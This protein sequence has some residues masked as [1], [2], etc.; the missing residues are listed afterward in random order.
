MY[1]VVN[2]T[3]DRK[4]GYS[5]GVAGISAAEF[6][7]SMRK[8]GRKPIFSGVAFFVSVPQ[9]VGRMLRG[10]MPA[11]VTL[12]SRSFNLAFG[13]P[14]LF[15]R[16]I[17]GYF[18]EKRG[19]AMGAQK[20]AKSAQT[21]KHNHLT[22]LESADMLDQL[23]SRVQ[24]IMNAVVQSSDWIDEAAG[25]SMYYTLATIA[26]DIQKVSDAVAVEIKS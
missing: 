3:T 5:C 6:E 23:K 18:Y 12:F 26:D 1:N 15:E 11:A 19:A 25:S 24:F 20:R 2:L 16:K 4:L 13:S 21:L 10:F 9:L 7:R 22:L 14:F 8:D 17:G